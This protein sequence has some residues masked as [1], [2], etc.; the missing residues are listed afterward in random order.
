MGW[1]PVAWVYCAEIFPLEHRSV[2]VGYTTC[3]NW[4]GNF[5]VALL[6][7]ILLADL[8]LYTFFLVAAFCIVAIVFSL[9][10]PETKGVSLEAMP[11]IFKAKFGIPNSAGDLDT[12]KDMGP[13]LLMG[14]KLA[15]ATYSATD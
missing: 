15:H 12:K 4:L 9:W 2:A 14:E 8:G 7:P 6:T 11:A 10:I 1:G 13:L 5:I 3:T